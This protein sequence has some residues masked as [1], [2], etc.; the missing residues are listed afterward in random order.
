MEPTAERLPCPPQHYG[1]DQDAGTQE[2]PDEQVR[3]D[4]CN[5]CAA[6]GGRREGCG[7]ACTNESGQYGDAALGGLISTPD[8]TSF[9]AEDAPIKGS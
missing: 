7:H 6:F 8:G 9:G 5:S 4:Q 2:C 1:W 3:I